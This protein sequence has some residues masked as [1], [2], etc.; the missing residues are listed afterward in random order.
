MQSGYRLYSLL[1]DG[2][3]I[4]YKDCLEEPEIHAKY[5]KMHSGRRKLVVKRISH[6]PDIY[7]HINNGKII[8]EKECKNSLGDMAIVRLTILHICCSYIF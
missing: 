3:F 5:K 4:I 7:A 8:I 2:S 6:F 1:Y